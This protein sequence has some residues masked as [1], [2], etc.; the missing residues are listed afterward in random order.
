MKLSE[1][2]KLIREEAA[3]VMKEGSIDLPVIPDTDTAIASI[4]NLIGVKLSKVTKGY[5]GSIVLTFS[6]G[7]MVIVYSKKSGSEKSPGISI[8]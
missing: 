8:R 2:R 1:F 7:T 3:N 5:Y 4:K 6:D